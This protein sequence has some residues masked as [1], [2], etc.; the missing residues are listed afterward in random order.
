MVGVSAIAYQ[1]SEK[2]REVD[3]G[4]EKGKHKVVIPDIDIDKSH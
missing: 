1:R 4:L 2:T 3:K